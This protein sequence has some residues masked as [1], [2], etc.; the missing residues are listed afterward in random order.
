[1]KR[2]QI[3]LILGFIAFFSIITGVSLKVWSY[4]IGD[5]ILLIGFLVL[6]IT[7]FV[8]IPKKKSF[9]DRWM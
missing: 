3:I 4:K 2:V 6:M 7:L 8:A 5:V 9:L 1:M